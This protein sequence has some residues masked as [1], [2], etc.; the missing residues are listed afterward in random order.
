MACITLMNWIPSLLGIPKNSQ[1]LPTMQIYG[2]IFFSF[3]FLC[4]S[5]FAFLADLT[6]LL[7]CFNIIM[8]L[9]SWQVSCFLRIHPSTSLGRLWQ[10]DQ[11]KICPQI[12]LLIIDKLCSSILRE[13]CYQL[14]KELFKNFQRVPSSNWSF[15]K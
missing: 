6:V 8:H 2:K 5:C 1:K 12:V 3:S 7:C 4:F 15:L 14:F 9:N 11:A 10:P 13:E